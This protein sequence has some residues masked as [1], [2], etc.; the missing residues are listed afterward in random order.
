LNGSRPHVSR[1]TRLLLTIALVSVASL[2]LLARVRYPDRPATPN[3]VPPVLA[4]F[5]PPSP[6]DAIAAS[7][8][9][10][11]PRLTPALVVLDQ[12]FMPVSA[13]APGQ[14]EL[15]TA[16]RLR[17]DLAVLLLAGGDAKDRTRT[18]Q[19]SVVARDGASGL[20]L[21][22][23]PGAPAPPLVQW[24]AARRPAARFLVAAGGSPNGV[25]FQPI[26]LGAFHP[27][28]SALWESEVWG[29]PSST[30]LRPGTFVFTPD[31]VWAGLSAMLDGRPVLVPAERVAA[32][33]EQLIAGRASRPGTLGVEVQ[34]ITP[35]L[36]GA[37]GVES[38][39][40]VT[41]VDQRGPAARAL[42]V[43]DVI[44]EVDQRP[45]HSKDNWT[46]RVARLTVGESVRVKIQRGEELSDVKLTAAEVAPARHDGHGLTLRTRRGLGAEIVSV[47]PGSP[48]AAAGFEAGDL[49]THVGTVPNPTAAQAA[50]V[51]AATSAGASVVIALER[52]GS[53]RVIALQRSW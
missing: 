8:R 32:I 42:R 36:A 12:R 20:A 10:V 38:G 25:S 26:F 33:G 1:E 29:L 9:E 41:W 49:L 27:I 14:G 17:D 7:V 5:V 47:E 39:V 21:V 19:G 13:D 2:W 15:T 53:H 50:R 35:D 11:E 28:F 48:A 30:D 44:R 37:V 3:P 31:G 51:L 18:P 16:L 43:M 40:I 34:S 24:T 45:V 4:P 6:L 23:V 22:T 52:A 46:V